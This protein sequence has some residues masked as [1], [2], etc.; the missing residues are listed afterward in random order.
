MIT[1]VCDVSSLGEVLE[2]VH[3]TM[4]YTMGVFCLDR[5]FVPTA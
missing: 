1:N 4:P 2:G 5:P 3:I